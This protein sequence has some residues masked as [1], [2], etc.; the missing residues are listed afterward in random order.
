[1]PPEGRERARMLAFDRQVR[2]SLNLPV[3]TYE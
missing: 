2:D 1:M 3:I